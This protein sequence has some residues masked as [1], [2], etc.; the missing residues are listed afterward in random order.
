MSVADILEVFNFNTLNS[1]LR[2]SSGKKALLELE[3]VP[4]GKAGVISVLAGGPSPEQGGVEIASFEVGDTCST[5]LIR[6]S[7]ECRNLRTL[8]GKQALFFVFSSPE[9]SDAAVAPA[10]GGKSICELHS[11]RFAVH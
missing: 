2:H 3:I 8:K 10:D 7:A 4:E 6:L 5:G 11:F 1:A 9:A